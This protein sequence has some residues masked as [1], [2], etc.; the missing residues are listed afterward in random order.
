MTKDELL[1]F[2]KEAKS[3]KIAFDGTCHDCKKSVIVKAD[4]TP[5]EKVVISGGAVYYAGKPKELYLKCDECFG[6]DSTLKNFQPCEVYSRIVGYLR[7][8]KQWNEGKLSEF[9]QRVDYKLTT[10]E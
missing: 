8:L 5:D 1:E 10:A 7:P 9:G 3:D 2:F 4:L 6:Q